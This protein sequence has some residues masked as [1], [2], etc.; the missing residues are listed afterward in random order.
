MRY[1]DRIQVR[2]KAMKETDNND[3]SVLALVMEAW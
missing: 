1:A 2:D 3:S